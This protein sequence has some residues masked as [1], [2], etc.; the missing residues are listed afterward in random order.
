MTR[1]EYG[2]AFYNGLETAMHGVT[3]GTVSSRTAMLL[4]VYRWIITGWTGGTLGPVPLSGRSLNK[5]SCTKSLPLFR[6][7]SE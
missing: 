7:V 5:I 4:N 3:E 6:V 2:M 1:S